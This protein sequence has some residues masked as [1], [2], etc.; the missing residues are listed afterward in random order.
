MLRE[1]KN[2]LVIVENYAENLRQKTST[3]LCTPY[4]MYVK[5]KGKQ[6]LELFD[7]FKHSSCESWLRDKIEASKNDHI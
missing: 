7:F 3:T 2:W 4:F 1:N 6:Y 5:S